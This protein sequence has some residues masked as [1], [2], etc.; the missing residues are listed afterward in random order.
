MEPITFGRWL[1]RLRAEQDLTQEM[2]A[3]QIG[4]ATPT[5]RSFEI[6]K[7]RPSRAM[8][9]HIATVLQV[10][11]EERPEFL[12]LARLPV[13]AQSETVDEEPEVV[14]EPSAP[15]VGQRLPLVPVGGALI[16]RE[17]ECSV[18]QRLLLEERCR[19]VTILG[20]GGMGKTR[21]AQQVAAELQTQFRDGASFVPLTSVTEGRHVPLAIAE[22]LGLSLQQGVNAQERLV[23]LLADRELLLVLDNFEHL[24][25]AT[26]PETEALDLIQ[27]LL[28]R[29][30]GVRLL[31]RVCPEIS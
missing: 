17:A 18:L 25:G 6:G 3:E 14:P 28:S 20:P 15:A 30:L 1:K 16:G 12:R 22:V 13:E 26:T 9:E 2:L 4:C 8:A 31:L 19:L 23:Q 21:L 5:L 7:R 27:A 10:S 11:A 24:L 29:T